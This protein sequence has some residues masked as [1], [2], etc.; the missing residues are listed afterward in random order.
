MSGSPLRLKLCQACGKENDDQAT[1]CTSCGQKF[2]DQPSPTVQ[3][4]DQDMFG[5]QLMAER[6]PGAHQHVFTDIYLRNASGELLLAAKKPSLLHGDYTIVDGNGVTAGSLTPKAHLTHS[7]ITLQDANRVPQG[8]VQHNNFESSRQMGL[9][10]QRVP[11][12]CWFVD[13]SGNTLGTVQFVNGVLG[14]SAVK[15]DG[16]VAFNAS[17]S[18]GD[19]LVQEMAA[20][21]H[22]R[23]AIS[24]VD[25]SFPLPMLLAM[26]TT[27]DKILGG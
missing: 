7:E 20:L 8:S 21:E 1:F 2:P 23:F 25:R 6:G 17:L 14:F 3:P 24:L 9:Y 4:L 19:G 12:K 26:I 11:P 18:G 10:R 15:A 22:R 27:V 5:L 16:T 13:A